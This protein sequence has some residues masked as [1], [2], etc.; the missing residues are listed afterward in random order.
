MTSPCENFLM[1]VLIILNLDLQFGSGQAT[2]ASVVIQSFGEVTLCF[3]ASR[4]RTEPE[5]M[6]RGSQPRVVT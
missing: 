2:S 6:V 3:A 1:P 4:G 5:S